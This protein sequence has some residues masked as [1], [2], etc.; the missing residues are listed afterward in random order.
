MSNL[1][2]LPFQQRPPP[3][4]PGL[5]VP[6]MGGVPMG[7]AQSPPVDPAVL[8]PLPPQVF[9][10]MMRLE[11]SSVRLEAKVDLLLD[12][13]TQLIGLQMDDAR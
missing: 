5:M 1:L 8:P 12:T 9:N 7:G 6:P 2:A 13:Q 4:G 11:A 10:L 3:P